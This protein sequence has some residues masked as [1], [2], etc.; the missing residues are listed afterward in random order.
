VY[1]IRYFEHSKIFVFIGE[2]ADERVTKI[3]SLDVVF[4]EKDF[5]TT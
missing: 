3:K 2:K 5:P 4:L 1:L